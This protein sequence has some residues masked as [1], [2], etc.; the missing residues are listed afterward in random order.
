MLIM[1]KVV[2]ENGMQGA[3]YYK[4]YTEAL[5]AAKFRTSFSNLKWFVRSVILK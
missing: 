1:Y 5:E 2:C 3:K 4:T